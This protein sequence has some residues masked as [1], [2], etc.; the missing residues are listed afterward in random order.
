MDGSSSGTTRFYFH[1]FNGD[2]LTDNV[3]WNP[4][5]SNNGRKGPLRV[6]LS[7]GDGTF[8]P[9]IDSD[10]S[11][12]GVTR[13]YFYDFNG[14]GLTDNVYWNPWYNNNGR[15]GP[16]RVRL[17]KGDGTFG[18]Y[19][20]MDGS[21]SGT[22]RFY[23]H[24]FNGDGLTD[25]VYWNPGYSNNGRKGPLRVRLSKGDGT[26]GP[27]I[28]SDGS[29]TGVT[30][31]YFYDF[32]GDGLTDNVYWNPWYNNNGRNGPLRVR[33]GKGD[34]T[35]GP[36][37]EI[38]GS[39]T[40]TTRF[41]FYDFNGDGLT[42]NV[43]WNPGYSNNGRNGPLRMRINNHKYG[44]I[45][46][47]D[48][49]GNRLSV[50]YSPI[51]AYLNYK[52][53]SYS[54]YPTLDLQNATHVVSQVKRSNG[55][56]GFN[57][58]D[59]QYGGLKANM[60]GRGSLGFQW[61]KAIQA[62]N[63][64]TIYTEYNQGFPLTGTV[65]THTEGIGDTIISR[66]DYQYTTDQANGLAQVALNRK[67]ETTYE[68][69]GQLVSQQL[70]ETTHDAFANP[71]TIQQTKTAGGQSYT[72]TTTTQ[73]LN[74][75]ARWLLGKPVGVQ[76]IYNDSDHTTPDIT[77]HSVFSYD[78][79]TGLRK[80]K[81][82][83]PNSSLRHKTEYFYDNYGNTI[84]VKKIAA[85]QERISHTAYDTQGIYVT[86]RTNPLN[87][88]EAYT[89][90]LYGNLISNI[91]P[92]KLSTHW[93]Y[94]SLGR[95]IREIRADGT[96]TLTEYTWDDSV[97]NAVY[98]VTTSISGQAPTA[99]IYDHLDRPIRE[100]MTGYDGK[101]IFRDMIYDRYGRISKQSLPYYQ[102][103]QV[104]WLQFAYDAL[105]RKITSQRPAGDGVNVYTSSI[106][107]AGLTQTQIDA[108]GKPKTITNN[109]LGLPVKIVDAAGG[110]LQYR[111][112]AKGNLL[113]TIDVANNST[114]LTYDLYDN[115]IAINDPNLGRWTYQYN[116]FGE[117]IQQQD[118]KGQVMTMAY[119]KLGRMISRNE[120][121]GTSTWQ[122]DNTA[123]AI[124]KLTKVTAPG[125]VKTY[126]YDVLGRAK[127]TTQSAADKILSLTNYYD[128]YSR[129]VRRDHP[130]GFKLVYVYNQSGYLEKIKTPIRVLD[131]YDPVHLEKIK[132]ETLI[133][134]EILLAEIEDYLELALEY[135][136][137]AASYQVQLDQ[138]IADGQFTDTTA[139]RQEIIAKLTTAQGQLQNNEAV[140]TA[141]STIESAQWLL[142]NLI[143]AHQQQ[144]VLAE[145]IDV[146][147]QSAGKLEDAATRNITLVQENLELYYNPELVDELKEQAE[148]YNEDANDPGYITYWHAH[149]YDAA[150]RLTSFV[151]G[152]GLVTDRDYNPA[153]QLEHIRTGFNYE[154]PVRELDY[155]YDA[156]NNVVARYNQALG[157]SS[158]FVYDTLDR[159]VQSQT[160]A[161]TGSTAESW[162]YDAQGNMTAH[163]GQGY[164]YDAGRPHAVTNAGDTN[165]AYDANGNIISKRTN[166][167]DTSIQWTSFNKPQTFISAQGT[168]GFVYGPERKRYLKTLA[169]GSTTVY[170][171][172]AYEQVTD[173]SG[174]ITH[175]YFIYAEGKL[176]AMHIHN[177][178][179]GSQQIRYLH[180]DNLDSV[181]TI[182]DGTGKI[183][184]RASY[185]PFGERQV[186]DQQS[187][188]TDAFTKRGFTGHEHIAEL[189]LIHMNGRV[190]DPVI[191]RFLSPDKY[192]QDPGNSQNYNRYAYVLNNPLKYTDPSGDFVCGGLCMAIVI[193]AAVNATIEAVVAGIESDWDPDTMLKGA[194]K[195]AITGAVTGAIGFYAA[196][197]VAGVSGLK[198][199]TV[200]KSGYLVTMT[201]A[202][203]K[204]SSAE[205]KENNNATQTNISNSEAALQ[206]INTDDEIHR[207]IQPE[208]FILLEG[209]VGSSQELLQI[210]KIYE[211]F[212]TSA[213]SALA[214]EGLSN[215]TRNDANANTEEDEDA[216]SGSYKKKL[217]NDDDASDTKNSI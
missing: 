118:A 16:L 67:T 190:Y 188:L 207:T 61:I 205:A 68:L 8:G 102:G 44:Y 195:G 149:R 167:G 5:Y 12:T 179:S 6:R 48:S 60:H 38:D 49:D 152:N 90:D 150:G 4:G 54:L 127:T 99:K 10:G 20:E 55:I 46:E 130:E 169:D 110:V 164:S 19:T 114:R 111:Y 140:R 52:K 47:M 29:G 192:I 166:E 79:N 203:W 206:G 189:N 171:D 131:G 213:A 202:S 176:L 106:E 94:D 200:K 129:V 34:G 80:S 155:N 197:Y 39:G 18:P 128:A 105:G 82:T 136:N 17:G 65:K 58:T 51:A 151:L 126:T 146:L 137:L 36:Y 170:L 109:A 116:A 193:S 153:G 143:Q 69:N 182:T 120:P 33:L 210:D 191:G 198:L 163:N 159:L 199:A 22:T 1:D 172:K 83:E 98:R 27:Y 45:S 101:I 158:Q 214:M 173:S 32:N 115:R 138:L 53:M 104:Y 157:I 144:I 212:L 42:D 26:F 187:N 31:F 133:T 7:K 50:D 72:E 78:A 134:A 154:T 25:N 183:V 24:D 148:Y 186:V 177:V 161:S 119:D 93:Q 162:T 139:L 209:V 208:E 201:N 66:T 113:E 123:K 14:D 88:G 40:D 28:D 84:R 63:N 85:G 135:R 185:D 145:S 117:L 112:D 108:K 141:A 103:D 165:Y 194:V 147:Q 211:D 196:P 74:D 73:Y 23:F 180:R 75:T 87:H 156:N 59:Y 107:Y 160:S 100:I 122:Y 89:Y 3:Y 204:I 174:N 181:D 76:V 70:T 175:K 2:G 168:T 43:Y 21:S 15:N 11:G 81:T 216:D 91:G 9:Y 92:N 71:T 37:T 121:E 35:F 125:Y 178:A 96:E 124:G 215:T 41:Y 97:A 142:N 30:R 13:F 95:T 77:R 184:Q 86:R 62:E 64:K 132:R 56:G 57:T 217:D